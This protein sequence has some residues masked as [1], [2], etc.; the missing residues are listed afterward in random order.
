VTSTAE[1]SSTSPSLSA[2]AARANHKITLTSGMQVTIRYPDLAVLIE[3]DAL[4]VHLR[5][6][7]ADQW[8]QG[9][10][11]MV[12]DAET[13]AQHIDPE[14]I[15]SMAQ[16]RR[17]LAAMALVEPKVDPD[18]FLNSGIPSEDIDMLAAIVMRERDV[19]ALG[20][21]LG[22]M[23]LSRF[24]TFREVH[25]CAEDCEA[26]AQVSGKFSTRRAVQV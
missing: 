15:K 5:T 9:G 6:V 26:C 14:T 25:G 23:P 4:P 1:N 19:D 7:A 24:D 10:P 13:G 16:L 2:W 12:T 8:S 17:H 21:K 3:G 22:V 11:S 20:V 18:E